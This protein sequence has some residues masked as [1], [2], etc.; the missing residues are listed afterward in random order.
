[1]LGRP[2]TGGQ[3]VYILDQVRALE[4]EMRSRLFE[5]GLD[6]EPQIVVLT[7]LIPQAEGTSCDQRLEPVSGTR[8]ARILRV[9][10]RNVSGEVVT[11]WISRFEAWTRSASCSPNW[12]GVPT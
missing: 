9:P 8:N 2:D 7:R 4:T 6:I 12:A 3:V 10:F 1:V 5:Q 11:H